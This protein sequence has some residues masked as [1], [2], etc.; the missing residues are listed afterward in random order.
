MK[1]ITRVN[2]MEIAHDT[3]TTT[4]NVGDGF[5]ID[6]VT[7]DTTREAW[8]YHITYGIKSLMFGVAKKDASHMSFKHMVQ[9]A[10]EDYKTTYIS[11]AIDE[12]I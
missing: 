4:Y 9:A 12:E 1:T 8:I 10:I 6:I 11:K 5:Y 3:R 2:K 7:D